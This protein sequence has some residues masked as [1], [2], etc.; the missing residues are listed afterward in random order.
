MA[1]PAQQDQTTVEPLL[2]D[3]TAARHRLGNISRSQLYE[4]FTEGEIETVKIG[5]RRLVVV[6]S[7][8]A[9]VGRLRTS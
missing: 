1:T 4:L 6:E 2:L 3:V 7:V 9:Y 8:D 5:K